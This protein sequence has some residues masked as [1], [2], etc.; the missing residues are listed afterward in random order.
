MRK[1]VLSLLK[2]V[3]I[4]SL[5]TIILL[6]IGLRIFG[7]GSFELPEFSMISNPAIHIK[8][9]DQLGVH[10]VPGTY[11]VTLNKKLTYQAT[12]LENGQRTCGESNFDG[13]LL[14][15]YGCSFTYGTG[16]N[17]DEVY[18]HLLQQEFDSLRI[19]NRAVPGY[20]QAQ[21][22]A[23]LK[24]D[25]EKKEKPTVLIL[26]YLSFHNER[27]AMNAAYRQKI[28]MG[29]EIT[30]RDEAGIEQFKCSY[31]FGEIVDG[32]L[33]MNKIPIGEIN[34]TLPLINYSAITNSLQNVFDQKSVDVAQDEKITLAMIDRIHE[35]CQS[36]GVQLVI[37][38]MTDDDQ[39]K[40]LT[41]H[42][43]KTSIP[44][45]DITVDLTQKGYT[46][47]PYDQHPSAIA[48][49][50]FAEKLTEYFEAMN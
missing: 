41:Q 13:P 3:L 42:C 1:K 28:R 10:L 40:R 19:E 21:V 50:I 23:M 29:Y 33:K 31:P 8:P 39:T 15:F 25:F 46:N 49:E 44:T 12:H 2:R 16:V 11:Q 35:L 5:I 45:I 37:S 7:F 9:D 34:S 48:H 6:E 26:N 24:D 22:L 27:N 18:P 17:D 36:Q 4:S 30:K 32:K 47:A 43:A 14:A 20:G 38:Y